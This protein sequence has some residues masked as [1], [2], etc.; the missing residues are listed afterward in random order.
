MQETG[1]TK[2]PIQERK[3]NGTG[4]V[5]F[6]VFNDWLKSKGHVSRDKAVFAISSRKEAGLFG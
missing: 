1:I 6:S 5:Y 3:P 2:L 4:E